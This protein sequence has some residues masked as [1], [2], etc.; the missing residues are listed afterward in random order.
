MTPDQEARLLAAVDDDG[1]LEALAELVAIRSLSGDES[2][3]QRWMADFLAA[4]G[5][6]VDR[7]EI[8]LEALAR[9]P[10]YC[11]EVDRAEALGVVG[12]MGAG[13]G[14]TLIFNGHVDVV[15]AGDPA[16]WSVPP[17]KT[18]V[19][20]GH[21][22]G[23]GALDMKGGLLCAVFAARALRAAGLRLRGR[24]LI[25]SVVGEEDG[26][27]GTLATI[28]RG[29]TGDAAIVVEPTEMMVAPAQAGALNF[30]VT[31]PG[32][33]AHGCFRAEGIDPITHFIPI[34]QALQ[35]LEA[36]RNRQQSDPLFAAYKLPYAICVGQLSAGVWASTVAESL[37]FAGRFGVSVGE[38]LGA[39]RRSLERCVAAA[40][41]ADPWLREAPPRVEWWGGQ[42]APAAIA[43]D[44]PLVKTV[45]A[46][47]YRVAG[48][49]PRVQ[50]MPYGADM[51]LLINQGQ[52]PT[53]LFG[54]GDVRRAHQPDERVPVADLRAVT[55]TLALTAA[56]FCGVEIEETQ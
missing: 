10:A 6:A 38:D 39:A 29:H 37:T 25:H 24:L 22:Y 34:Y 4:S 19:R 11:A 15:P 31:I 50:G 36:E 55:R 48:S 2:A 16:N 8:D 47:F 7:W 32:R 41:A 44:H 13:N 14:P 56:R 52:T 54:P 21:V 17:W 45:A 46:A 40:A 3:A 30:R 42:F 5:L 28:L 23:R 18:T 43:A 26:G 1:L 33:A 51:R 20:D 9:H 49:R 35:Q 12:S 53:V 27:L